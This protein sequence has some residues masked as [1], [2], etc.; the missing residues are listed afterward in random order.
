MPFFPIIQGLTAKE[1]YTNFDRLLEEVAAKYKDIINDEEREVHF[2]LI[3][4]FEHDIGGEDARGRAPGTT[5]GDLKDSLLESQY[6][7]SLSSI[8][9]RLKGMSSRSGKTFHFAVVRGAQRAI[10][11]ILPVAGKVVSWDAYREIRIDSGAIDSDFDFLNSYQELAEPITFYYTPGGS[12][13]NPVNIRA[14]QPRYVG[15]KLRIGLAS[16][17]ASNLSFPLDVKVIFHDGEDGKSSVKGREGRVAIGEGFV[18][19]VVR[20][21]DDI[22]LEPEAV[23]DPREASTYRKTSPCPNAGP[24]GQERIRAGQAVGRVTAP[25]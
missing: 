18:G 10:C 21:K 9:K 2:V 17:S 14:D 8:G 23:I 22:S 24:S 12:E 6:R 13:P 20:E 11:S 15:A 19:E 4:D 25:G 3:S 16:R 7:V 1:N 5:I